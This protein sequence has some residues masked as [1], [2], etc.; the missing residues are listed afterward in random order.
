MTGHVV[1]VDGGGSRTRAVLL[2]GAGGETGRWEGAGSAIDPRAPE[3]AAARVEAAVRAVAGEAGLPLPV[4]GLTAGLA[5]AGDADLR[6]RV[7]TALESA[8]MARRVIVETDADAG[9]RDAFGDGPGILLIAGTGS[10]ACGR[11][12]DGRVDR[13]GGW[14]PLLGDEGS[15]YALGLEALRRVVRSVDGRAPATRLVDGLARALDL[16]DPRALVVWVAGASR[17]EV[18]AL[19]PAVVEAA[20][21]GDLAARE[22]LDE[23]ARTLA[24]TAAVLRDRLGPWSRP[25]PLAPMGGLLDPAAPLR[26][27]LEAALTPGSWLLS[28]RTVNAAR[29]AALG[30]LDAVLHD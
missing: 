23:A 16:L 2:D 4:A 20:E 10:V 21:D 14:G 8:G 11:A 7:R 24:H 6:E 5:G 28:P 12:E 19:V 25:T 17:A 1:G 15:G 22:L 29:G 9:F 13:V 26:P 3:E 30:A 18:A 27:R